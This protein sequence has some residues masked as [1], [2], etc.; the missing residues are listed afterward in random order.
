MQYPDGDPN[1]RQIKK[2][3]DVSC[4]GLRCLKF[5]D[6]ETRVMKPHPIIKGVIKWISDRVK[7]KNFEL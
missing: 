5:V 7:A 1:F 3:K 6:Y 2:I 4:Q